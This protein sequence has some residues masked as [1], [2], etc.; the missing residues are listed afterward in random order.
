MRRSCRS[1][2][3]RPAAAAGPP[4]P[5]GD[6][7]QGGWVARGGR[8]VEISSF[9]PTLC[10]SDGIVNP[11]RTRYTFFNMSATRRARSA[12]SAGSRSGWTTPHRRSG[13]TSRASR[14][15]PTRRSCSRTP[16]ARS[17]PRRRAT[18]TSPRA[19]TGRGT[20]SRTRRR[21]RA[22]PAR[23]HGRGAAR[24]RGGHDLELIRDR[25]RQAGHVGADRDRRAVAVLLR[26]D[27]VAARL[28]LGHEPAVGLLRRDRADQHRGAG[29]RRGST[30]RPGA[31]RDERDMGQRSDAHAPVAALLARLRANPGRDRCDV[32]PGP[33]RRGQVAA[34]RRDGDRTGER[35]RR[36]LVGPDR[37][38]A[39][40]G[41]AEHGLPKVTGEARHDEPLFANPGTWGDAPTSFKYQWRRCASALPESCVDVAGATTSTYKATKDDVGARMR[42]RVTGVN[43][44]GPSLPADSAPTGEVQRLVVRAVLS[45]T[46]DPSCT[47]VRD[48]RCLRLE[49]AEPAAHPLPAQLQDPPDPGAHRNHL[50]DRVRRGRRRDARDQEVPRKRGVRRGLRRHQ[51]VD[52]AELQLE[53]TAHQARAQHRQDRRLRARPGRRHADG[54]R[55]GGR[56]V[57]ERT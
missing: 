45:M 12:S 48:V 13:P 36:R 28:A 7:S 47:G 34:R 27:V 11:V 8:T 5:V 38:R 10:T 52:V 50:R 40:R 32:H 33:R 35:G 57:D 4:Q 25:D 43:A 31:H 42:V 55:Q 26:P 46:P 14:S 6:G 51:P 53:P 41:A 24:A 49:D 1:S 20:R 23:E 44:L 16:A 30:G 17:P 19:G 9:R 15:P 21:R 3:A 2:G 54:H 56:D 39:G 18:S 22:R 29:D 37:R